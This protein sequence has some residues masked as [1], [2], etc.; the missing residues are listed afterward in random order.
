MGIYPSLRRTDA[1]VTFVLS[2]RL[3]YGS[4]NFCW[5]DGD[6]IPILQDVLTRDWLTVDTNQ[7][8]I[9][10]AALHLV[11]EELFNSHTFSDI[12][13]ICKASTIVVDIEQSQFKFLS[14]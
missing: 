7:V 13:I 10:F 9:W 14:I 3:Y 12:N 8:V 6:T 4:L 11:F 1:L 2:Q 5:R